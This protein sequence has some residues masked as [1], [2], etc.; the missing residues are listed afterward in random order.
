MI[1]RT[2]GKYRNKIGMDKYE[3]KRKTDNTYM[4]FDLI[5]ILKDGDRIEHYFEE[6]DIASI[7][8]IIF[9]GQFF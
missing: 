1:P 9:D 7:V 8:E 2:D 3:N 5:D 6:A 4:L